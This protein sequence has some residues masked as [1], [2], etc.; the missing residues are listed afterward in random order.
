[1][2]ETQFNV[3]IFIILFV[4]FAGAIFFCKILFT[5][6]YGVQEDKDLEFIETQKKEYSLLNFLAIFIIVLL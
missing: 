5:I 4:N 6:I 1:M 2:V 3:L